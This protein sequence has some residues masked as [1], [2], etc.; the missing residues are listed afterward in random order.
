[1]CSFCRLTPAGKTESDWKEFTDF[2]LSENLDV[3]NMP[4]CQTVTHCYSSVCFLLLSKK[5]IA[6]FWHR[7]SKWGFN[8]LPMNCKS[9]TISRPSGC[10][11]DYLRLLFSVCSYGDH[12][13]TPG[14]HSLTCHHTT[15]TLNTKVNM[16]Q[17]LM[18]HSK[19]FWYEVLIF[20]SLITKVHSR[21]L[22]SLLSKLGEIRALYHLL[23]WRYKSCSTVE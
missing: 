7:V 20:L 5:K 18:P 22:T 6:L 14:Y 1:M 11:A 2:A 8:S 4:A 10:L 3:I 13:I 17:I 12:K 23:I 9:T 16:R 19:I 21:K 15:N